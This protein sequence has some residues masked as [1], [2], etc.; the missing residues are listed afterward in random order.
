MKKGYIKFWG[1]RGSH[2]TPDLNKMVYGGD[3]S[4]VEVRTPDELFIFD[5]G[6]GLRN[7]GSAMLKDSST[8]KKV[9]IFLSHYHWDHVVGMLNFS[10]LFDSSFTF[11]IYG[12]NKKTDI[13]ELQD[14]LLDTALWPVSKDMLNAKINFINLKKDLIQ[15]TDNINIEHTNHPHPN[16]ATS[17][18]IT[19]DDF[20]ILYTTDCE[21]TN[22]HLNKNVTNIA[23]DVDI[24][25]HDAHFS[26]KDL[27][28]HIGW[29]HSSW[30]DA[31][32]VA[33]TSNVKQLILYHFSPEYSDEVVS[34][35]EV[36]AQKEFT[37]TI[38]AKQQMKIEF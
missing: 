17:Y 13:N 16:G 27:S 37:N 5:M 9:N 6:S 12:A 11:N 25:I 38:A 15:I 23:K 29:G 10:P 1:V 14:K 21:H 35:I 34:N 24:L 33:K 2:P 30:K 8:P 18:K 22:N 32:D 36:K 7:L 4:C 3:T 20:S 28:K 19:I 26:K 31:V